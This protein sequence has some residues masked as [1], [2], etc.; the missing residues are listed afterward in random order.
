MKKSFIAVLAAAIL[1]AVVICTAGCVSNA[2]PIVGSWMAQDSTTAVAA[3][4]ETDGS[5]SYFYVSGDSEI[6]ETD[7]SYSE[8]SSSDYAEMPLR[9]KAD[10]NNVYSVVFASGDTGSCT[11][12]P[13]NGTFVTNN[14]VVYEKV[15]SGVLGTRLSD[16]GVLLVGSPGTGKTLLASSF[17]PG[18]YAIIADAQ[19]NGGGWTEEPE[20]PGQGQQK[21]VPGVPLPW[22]E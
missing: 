22:G 3:V 14:D 5:G 4:F 7:T 21:E 2:D 20:E 6:S 16:G 19:T 18:Y 10:G 12:N 8:S 15:P 11:L 13:Q 9:W 17:N 1:L